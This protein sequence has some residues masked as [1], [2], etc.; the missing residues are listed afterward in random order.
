MAEGTGLEPYSPCQGLV[1]GQGGLQDVHPCVDLPVHLPVAHLADEHRAHPIS[2]PGATHWAGLTGPCRVDF[3]HG[4]PFEGGLVL[5]LTVDLGTRPRRQPAIHSSGTATSAVKREVLKD[6]RGTTRLRETHEPFR[7]S[8][9][10][11]PDSVPLSAA[12]AIEEDPLDASVS[13]LLP[14]EPPPSSEVRLLDTPH[15]VERHTKEPRR[16]ARCLDP[17]EGILVRVQG[18]RALGLVGLRGVH[19]VPR[20]EVRVRSPRESSARSDVVPQGNPD[21]FVH[22]EAELGEE[23]TETGIL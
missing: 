19:R 15:T 7:D 6:N 11:L 17:V 20:A 5:D 14:R 10:P 22:E 8:M 2:A 4:N 16:I 23:P 21:R 18:D 12:F 1:R 9:E 3:D 13:R